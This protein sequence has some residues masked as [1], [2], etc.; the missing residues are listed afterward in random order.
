MQT[1][2]IKAQDQVGGICTSGF[3]GRSFTLGVAEAVTVLAKT[4]ATADAFATHLANH[5][6]V[7]SPRIQRKLAGEIDPFS[8]IAQLAVTTQV[9]SLTQA[10]IHI[11]LQ[12]FSKAAKVAHFHSHIIGSYA[13]MKGQEKVGK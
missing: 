13:Y 10:E 11:A 2:T 4:A 12:N 5:T 8:D 1:L 3:G 9:G 7:D 6:R